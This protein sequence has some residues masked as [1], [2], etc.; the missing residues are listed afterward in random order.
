MAAAKETIFS[1]WYEG[2]RLSFEMPNS[3]Y[4]D[5]LSDAYKHLL[6][7]ATTSTIDEQLRR[8]RVEGFLTELGKDPEFIADCLCWGAKMYDT[9]NLSGQYHAVLE[10]IRRI[11]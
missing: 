5:H 6:D 4:G 8:K 10:Q 9:P 11:T 2:V 7:V 3:G 1:P